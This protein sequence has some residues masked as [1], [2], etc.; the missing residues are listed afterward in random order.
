M[1]HN[2]KI[3]VLLTLANVRHEIDF[4]TTYEIELL[5]LIVLYAFNP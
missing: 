1:L 3:G 4:S 5:A 2:S